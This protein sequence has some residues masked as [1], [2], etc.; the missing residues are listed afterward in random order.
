MQPVT[1]CA[2]TNALLPYSALCSYVEAPVPSS[3][4]IPKFPLLTP[5]ESYLIVSDCPD[6]APVTVDCVTDHGTSDPSPGGD[7]FT[8]TAVAPTALLEIP[9]TPMNAKECGRLIVT[10]T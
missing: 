8:A 5:F 4:R 7:V 1:P 2:Q 9:S 10:D 6:V 3:A